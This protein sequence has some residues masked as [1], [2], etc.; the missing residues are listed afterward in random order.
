MNILVINAGSS[1]VK[2]TLFGVEEDTV[3]AA[4]MVERIGIRGTQ[5]DYR[6]LRGDEIKINSEVA[7][8]GQA[9]DAMTSL[10]M[11]EKLGVIRSKAEI[12]A[13]GHRVV[14]G[15]EKIKTSVL[16]TAEVKKIIEACFELAPLHNPLNMEGIKACETCF[17]GIPQVAVFD[18]AFH[19]TLPDYAY[20]YGLP[21]HLY[22]EDKIRRYGFHGT[23]HQYVCQAAAE[24][25]KQP[26]DELK[27]ISC[28]LGNGCSITAVD[29]GQ[30]IDTSMGFTP[31][32]GLIMGTRCGDLDPAIVFYLMDH[33]NLDARQINAL[34]NKQSGL[35][36]LAATGSSDLRDILAVREKGN[37]QAAT[38]IN[39][40]VYRIKK[41]I[42]AYTAALGGLNAIVFT[43]G[44]GENSALIREMVCSGMQNLGINLNPEKNTRAN[45]KSCQVQSDQS[46]VKIMVV[47]THEERAIALQT[48]Q[49]LRTE[50]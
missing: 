2:V 38:A 12:S 16:I 42:G 36:G 23:S 31:L 26:L 3:L 4:G 18:T 22:Q 34:F 43:A 11:D 5:L 28:H 44:I 39:A 10:L 37:Q 6:N 20:L 40:F 41:Y 30:S 15:G 35:L 7:D 8:T 17:R 14:H 45:G 46:R 1:S 50:G 19:T 47:P 13:I 33:K 25:L 9:I 27:I 24:L 21:Y 48:L 49:L 29:Q 32:E